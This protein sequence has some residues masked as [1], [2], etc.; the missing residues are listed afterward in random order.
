MK[1]EGEY[2]FAGSQDLVWSVLLDPEV[3]AAVLP[4][5]EKLDLVGENEYEGALK[6][7]V[8]PVQGKFMG[9]VKLADIREPDSYTMHVDGQGAPGFVKAV[10]NLALKGSGSETLVTYEGDAQVGGK[11]A[12]VGQRLI[13]SSAKAIIK[14]SLDGLNAHVVARSSSTTGESGEGGE[15]PVP[16]AVEA[17]SEAA[18]AAAVAKEVARDLVPAWVSRTGLVIVV[19]LLVYLILRLFG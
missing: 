9:K 10:G 1:V 12:S 16:V 2:T 18:F 11:L 5:C 8:G 19:V 3:L 14:Q 7:K 17:P 4:G 6:I 13:E 15:S